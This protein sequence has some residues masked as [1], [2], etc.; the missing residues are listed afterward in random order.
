ML[1]VASLP[2]AAQAE[3]AKDEAGPTQQEI[4]AWL[5]ARALPDTRDDANTGQV[6]EAPPP[7][8]R[9]EGLVVETGLGALGHLGPLKNI[10][11]TAP[12]WYLHLG[13]EIF[14][15]AMIFAEGDVS[16]MNTGFAA[17]PPQPRSFAFWGV[18]GGVRFTV[19]PADR[20]GI[21]LQG[22]A[23]GAQA[24]TD[25]LEIYGYTDADE[26][27][28]YFAG[29]LGLEWY[30]VSRHL[31]LTANGGVRN[32]NEGLARLRSTETALAWTG[33]VSLRYAF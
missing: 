23:G 33:G 15:W 32:Y 19:R 16:F 8:P 5:E 2:A 4:E 22:S 30:Q 13:Y 7:P 1:G 3:D 27:K 25:V 28:P 18:G 31:A 10:T 12:R 20:F 14:S 17:P 9:A 11:P 24:T 21:Y 6:D 26:F 29:Q